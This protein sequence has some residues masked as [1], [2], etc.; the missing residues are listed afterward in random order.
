[1]ISENFDEDEKPVEPFDFKK[2]FYL[3]LRQW[4]WF[5]LFGILGITAAYTYNKL[6]KPRFVVSASILVPEKSSGMDM[7]S[8]FEGVLDQKSNNIFNQIEIIKSYY[9]IN[10]TLVNLKW[11]TSWYKKEMFIWKGIYNQEPFEVQETQDF[12]NLKG[13]PVY[14]TP[15]SG[16]AFLITVDGKAK[17][18]NKITEVKFDGKGTFGQPFSNTYFN[19]TLDKKTK[20]ADVTDGKFMFVFNDLNATTLAYQK[21]LKITLK[22]KNSDLIQCTIEGEE[23]AKE[24]EFLNELIKVYIESK[25]NLQNEAQKRSLEFINAQLTGI[26]DSLDI[27]GTKF[28]AFRSKNKIFDLGEQGTLVMNNL[29]EI[30]SEKAKSQ[31]QLDYFHN[32]LSYLSTPGNLKQLVSPSVVGIEDASLNMLVLKMGELYNRRQIISFSAKEN[33]PTLGLIDKEMTQTRTLINEN[34]RNLIDNATKSIKSLKDRQ[35][36]IS[37]ELNNLPQKEQQMINIQRQF[38]LTNE[39]YTFLLKKRAETNIALASSISDVQVIDI[40]RPA[41]ATPLGLPGRTILIIGFILGIA[42]PLG[43]IMLMNILDDSIRS[44]EDIENNTTIPTLGYIIF[45]QSTSFTTVAENPKSIIAES[46]RTLR[47]NL[48]FMLSEPGSKVISIQSINPGEGKSFIS[49]NLAAILAMNNKKVLLIGA[50]MRKP[51]LHKIFN[52]NNEHGLS[53]YLIGYDT[54]GQAILPTSIKN[55]SLLP[56]GPIPPNP[57]EILGKPEMKKLIDEVRNSYDYI[58]I[59]NAPVSMV[60]DGIIVS[61]LSDLNI[62]ILRYAMSHKHQIGM[63]NQYADKQ[64]INHLGIVV[65]GIKSNAFGYSFSKYSRY[66]V[67]DKNSYHNKYYSSE[68]HGTK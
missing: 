2:I 52:I 6:T 34:L 35:K 55:L 37:S 15:T 49:M 16:E 14:I 10:Q 28:T 12:V 11:K 23:P 39:I 33:N 29:K 40:A 43:I 46:F 13:I 32:L 63:I 3:M 8:I 68:E 62:F 19:F 24:G 54:I 4:Q 26:S 22:V 36:M 5:L 44:Q 57:A 21:K 45:D 65:N 59:D 27:A 1:M 50:D 67:Y 18:N 25:M 41:D 53:T 58:I 56:S 17:F 64:M 38:D 51:K 7:K 66:E 30:E 61:H 31:M 47:T 20:S 9:P 48:Q 60:T 42:I